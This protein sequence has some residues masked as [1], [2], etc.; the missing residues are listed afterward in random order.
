MDQALKVSCIM[1]NRNLQGLV[2]KAV[3][4]KD[5]MTME[6]PILKV[7]KVSKHYPGVQALS[8]IDFELKAGE[9]RALLGK[10]GAGKSTLVKILS[11]ATTPDSGVIYVEGQPRLLRSPADAFHAGI[12]TVYQ[13]MSLVRGLSVAENIMLGRWPSRKTL[14]VHRIDHKMTMEAAKEALDMMGVQLNLREMVGR[15]SVPEQQMVEI[16]KAVVLRPK[17]LILDEPTSALPQTEVDQLLALVRRLAKN[18]VGIIYVSHRLQ[19]IPRVADSLTVLRDGIH[20]GT[21]PIA[22]G[23]PERIANMMIGEEWSRTEMARRQSGGEVCLSVRGINRQRFLHDVSF[24]LHRGEVLGI[25]GLLGSGRTELLRAIFGLD[26]LDSGEIEV[27]GVKVAHP[28][29]TTM[30]AL[31]VGMT[32]EDRKAQGLVLLM[33]VGDNL[34]LSAMNRASRYQVLSLPALREMSNAM[35]KAMSITTP[36]LNTPTLSLSGGNQQKVVIGKWLNSKVKILLLD[37]P[38]RGIDIHAKEQVYS[39]VRELSEQGISVIFV[40]S[41]LEEVMNVSDR[42]LVMN[43]GRIVAEMPAATA[44]LEEVLALAMTEEVVQ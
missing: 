39:L 10:N 4:E 8:E 37:E 20:V 11:G 24:D 18:G 13:E 6:T 14:G 3:L 30:K 40:S 34:T 43:Q 27:N 22:E 15:L 16:A 31:G 28:A 44:E 29:P 23:T 36:G 38:T 25:A 41:E 32:P 42:I 35:V 19:E 21:I 9:V 1:N 5:C 2:Y 17:V 12:A 7:E 33:S 26:H